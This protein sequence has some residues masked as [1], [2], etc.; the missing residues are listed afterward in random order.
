MS[1]AFTDRLTQVHQQLKE[2]K[3]DC[4]ALVP[5][6]N[7]RFL[8]GIDFMLLERPLILFIPAEA[9]AVPL[10]VIPE[11]EV[12]NWKHLAPFEARLY[13]WPD[14][15]GPKKAMGQAAQALQGV[16]KLGVEHLRM[17]V[18][19]AELIRQ[20][21][22]K[23][24]L[25]R[26]EAVLNP[27]RLHKDKLELASH[28]KAV[29]VCEL[30]LE[31]TITGLSLGDTEKQICSRL[32]SAILKHGGEI[33]PIEPLVL[34]GPNAGAPHGHSGERRVVAGDML[35]FDFVTTVGGYYAD[36]T[37]TFVVGRKPDAHL[38]SVYQTVQ[39]ANAA[40]RAAVRPGA[41]CQDVDRAAR[42]VLV[43][44]GLG[45][46]FTHRT[47]H[48]L[49]LEVHEEPSIVEGNLMRLEAG[50]VFTVEPGS[51]LEGW[52]GVRIEDNVV[53]TPTGC[54]CLTTFARE[55]RIIES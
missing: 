35:L 1:T 40:G 55:L 7:L 36:I 41:T 50:M 48:G 27:L 13:P 10:L 37:R 30:A 14:Q 4:L 32:T 43:E 53:V 8:T 38:R 6:F 39:A 51:Y 9:S 52:G 11:L 42:Q 5:G 33:T 54:D 21:M 44:A 16:R 25:Y 28:R 12:A 19:E 26:G 49:G 20:F 3:L 22:P 17:R 2:E 24:E 29:R 23:T 15:L 34:G 18:L 47:G 46:S 45:D 31:E